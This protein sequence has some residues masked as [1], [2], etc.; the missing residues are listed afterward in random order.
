MRRAGCAE[1][2]APIAPGC[3][4]PA[5]GNTLLIRRHA[6]HPGATGAARRIAPTVVGEIPRRRD[7]SRSHRALASRNEGVSKKSAILL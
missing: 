6:I 2:G 7:I 3:F 1:P 5:A 4:D